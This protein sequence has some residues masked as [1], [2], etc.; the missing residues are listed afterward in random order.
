MQLSDEQQLAFKEQLVTN[1]QALLD[2]CVRQLQRCWQ[3]READGQ[4]EERLRRRTGEIICGL[5]LLLGT[6]GADSGTV[7]VNPEFEH[8]LNSIVSAIVAQGFTPRDASKIGFILRRALTFF[9]RKTYRDDVAL[10]A[11][12]LA[13]MNGLVAQFD[14]MVDQSER[15]PENFGLAINQN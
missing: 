4:L 7:A 8:N 5:A 2:S 1:H 12:H 15:E 6:D 3:F 13:L 14:V 9:M 10:L 11:E